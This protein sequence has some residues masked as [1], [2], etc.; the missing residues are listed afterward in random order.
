MTWSDPVAQPLRI[1]VVCTGNICRSPLAERVLQSR[2]DA[3]GIPAV[4]TSAGTS[5]MTGDAMTP[6]AAELAARYGAS[7]AGHA[8]R[9][10]TASLVAE[11]DLVLTATRAHRA[12]TVTLHPRATRYTFTLR[13]FARLADGARAE[14]D[15]TAEDR[16]SLPALIAGIAAHRGYFPPLADPA[17]D[18]IVDP[19]RMPQEVYDEAGEAIDA[20][21]AVVASV[22]SDSRRHGDA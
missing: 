10:L 7:A 21:T 1:L 22:F 12:A 8:A 2:L 6:Q 17:D 5:A 16:A 14:G 15:L 3:A 11:S 4:V 9:D 18:D 20:A 19:Y 13:E